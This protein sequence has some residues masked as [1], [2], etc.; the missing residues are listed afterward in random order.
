MFT[1]R[2]LRVNKFAETKVLPNC[3]WCGWTNLCINA[4]GTNCGKCETYY[5]SSLCSGVGGSCEWCQERSQC[6]NSLTEYCN[7]SNM[8]IHASCVSYTKCKWCNV[9]KTCVQS[10][11]LCITCGQQNAK[12]C[13]NYEICAYCQSTS[14]CIDTT[15]RKCVACS[16]ASE[17]A[18]NSFR[19]CFWCNPNCIE[20]ELDCT[21][22][23][24]GTPLS[25]ED[26]A[27]IAVLVGFATLC[28]I[29]A[30]IIYAVV[31]KVRDR[32]KKHVTKVGQFS[33]VYSLGSAVEPPKGI[34]VYSVTSVV[35][36]SV[37]PIYSSESC[38]MPPI[39]SLDPPPPVTTTSF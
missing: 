25:S 24:G 29:T 33:P 7:C 26:I 38:E 4:S 27:L 10:P 2:V 1:V 23:S 21:Y 34:P 22:T 28:A 37:P 6:I 13:A 8:Y 15:L 31:I 14:T 32:R 17:V 19:G 20:I 9:S 30:L 35:L 16:V 18:C 5:T 36:G 11:V 3:T 39:Y 12:Q